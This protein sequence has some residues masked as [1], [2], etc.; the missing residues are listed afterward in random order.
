VRLQATGDSSDSSSR[1]HAN[2]S[3]VQRPNSYRLFTRSI[4]VLERPGFD[5]TSVRFDDLIQT[6]RFSFVGAALSPWCFAPEPPPGVTPLET[7]VNSAQVSQ[8][9]ALQWCHSGS[10]RIFAV[11]VVV[12]VIEVNKAKEKTKK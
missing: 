2:I 3:I 5:A 10:N 11:S 6:L 9:L 4:P 1:Q 7:D 8:T 12:T